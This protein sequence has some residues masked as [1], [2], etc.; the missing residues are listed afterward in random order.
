VKNTNNGMAAGYFTLGGRPTKAKILLMILR[1]KAS[2]LQQDN[3]S[4]K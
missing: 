1:R 2:P 4:E 3:H